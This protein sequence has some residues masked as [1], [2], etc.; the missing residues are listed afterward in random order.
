MGGRSDGNDVPAHQEAPQK[1]VSAHDVGPLQSVVVRPQER[2]VVTE[3]AE[4]GPVVTTS[5]RDDGSESSGKDGL[6]RSTH[7]QKATPDKAE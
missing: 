1:K 7:E 4:I 2:V 6:G 3:P 5:Q